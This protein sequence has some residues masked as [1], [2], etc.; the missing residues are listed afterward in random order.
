MRIVIATGIYPPDIGG[1]ATYARE[2]AQA[3]RQLGEEVA[4]VSYAP[5][6]PP[7]AEETKIDPH[8]TLV[9]R[10]GGT[11]TRW[12]NYREAL[13]RVAARADVIYALSSV[14]A[15]VPLMLSGL[16]RP[17]LRVLR[18]GGD[19][20]WERA[21]DAGDQRTLREW[22]EANPWQQRLLARVLRSFDHIVFS[23]SF[24]QELAT[25][26][27]PRLPTHSVIEN[28]LPGSGAVPAHEIHTPLRLLA[29][30]RFVRFKNLENLLRALTLL[31]DCTLT[32]VGEGPHAQHLR[33]LATTLPGVA[34]RLRWLSPA[35]GL[36]KRALCDE[37]DLLVLPS[38][39]EI[40]PNAALEARAIGLPV[41][42]TEETGLSDHL[43]NGMLLRALRTSGQIA[44][45]I[46]EV[47]A[48]YPVLA[49][50][51]CT[52]LHPRPWSTLAQEHVDLF[53]TLRA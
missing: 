18:L 2:L 16:P 50:A 9:P 42:L 26:T 24:Q 5:H 21:T 49:A 40:S 30:Q 6:C 14:S 36:E 11:L 46:R 12:K 41:L 35:H 29:M 13:R 43:T 48:N 1:P 45:A 17:P 3:L 25:R 53:R 15:G 37:H 19:F 31:P 4:V 44:D 20:A 52:P 51:A 34:A 7:D 8:L 47:R 23:T 22:A 39:T 28:A 33:Q 38:L 10:N 32:L 27:M